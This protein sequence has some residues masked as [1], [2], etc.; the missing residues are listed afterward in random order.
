[1]DCISGLIF[2]LNNK[3][4]FIINIQKRKDNTLIFVDSNESINNL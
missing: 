4:Q 2:R 3:I 1:M